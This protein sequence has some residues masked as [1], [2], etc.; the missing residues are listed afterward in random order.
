[1]NVSPVV[2]INDTS[3]K[4]NDTLKGELLQ[5]EIEIKNLKNKVSNLETM[6]S[7]LEKK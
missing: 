4:D 5:K 1:F 7:I 2:F 3:L 6:V